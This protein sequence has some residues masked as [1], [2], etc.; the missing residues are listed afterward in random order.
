MPVMFLEV[1]EPAGRLDRYL[2]D[3]I[4]GLSRSAAQR[5]LK[6]GQVLVN[7]KPSKPSYAPVPGDII[8]V[9]IPA[10]EPV[11]PRPEP[12]PLAIL[13]ADE[14]LALINKPAGIA[15]HPGAGRR[16]G[17]LVN[18]L[19]ARYP[20]IAAQFPDPARPGIVH[21]LDRDTSGVLVVA[22]RRDVQL[23]LQRQF[24]AR[25]VEK[26]YLALVYG[27]PQPRR[28]A[29]E[30]PIGRNPVQRTRMAILAEGG[31]HARTEYTVRELFARPPAAWVEVRPLTGRTHQI[32]VHLSAIGHPVVG[33]LV[34]GYRRGE[35]PAPRQMLHSWRLGFRHP[36][37]GE[38]LCVEAP[39]PKDM[40]LVLARL[41]SA[42]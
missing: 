6:E 24:K 36:I 10:A 40:E 38:E 26:C 11:H 16:S 8:R 1:H 29:I 7:G 28:G 31:R 32:R 2:A 12:L 15:V 13:Y 9:E 14:Y 17:T 3:H 37:T 30:A 27:H 41:R 20:E 42:D 33:D 35:I 23:A 19:L 25:E 5:L 21:R 39:V 4:E 18:A 22:L 34:Y